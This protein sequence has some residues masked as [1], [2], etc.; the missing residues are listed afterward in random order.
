MKVRWIIYFAF[1]LVIAG[2]SI[3]RHHKLSMPSQA[4]WLAEVDLPV[5]TRI[6][7]NYLMKSSCPT[8][9]NAWGL[10]DIR[11]FDGKYV[12]GTNIPRNTE[13]ALQDLSPFPHPSESTNCVT[14]F[15]SSQ[16]LLFG[17]PD[18]C[19]NSGAK[20]S[21]S[22]DKGTTYGPYRIEAILGKGDS[23][24]LAV[25]VTNSDAGTVSKIA[26]PKLRIV[27]LQ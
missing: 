23:F 24:A 15:Y 14:L 5:N 3:A 21:I 19:I 13:V 9:L 22:D 12:A 1:V 18:G 8:P 26:K 7:T 2:L 4:V 10:E 27:S 16:D 17:I 20:I 6:F 11:D 25:L